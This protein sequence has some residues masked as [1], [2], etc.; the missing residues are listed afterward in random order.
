MSQ[1]KR[2]QTY[3]SMEEKVSDGNAGEFISSQAYFV[4][5][6]VLFVTLILAYAVAATESAGRN[7]PKKVP[8]LLPKPKSKK[9]EEKTEDKEKKASNSSTEQ[10]E[11]SSG[12][13]ECVGKEVRSFMILNL[14]DPPYLGSV[15]ASL[16][17]V[18]NILLA[19]CAL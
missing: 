7:S 9:G 11:E 19:D 18:S 8:L 5:C 6:D 2:R 10:L 16:L 1:M 14:P 3:D 4:E 13:R 12:S 15:P 17:V